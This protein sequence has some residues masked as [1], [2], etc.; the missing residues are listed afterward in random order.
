ML[1]QIFLSCVHL[2]TQRLKAAAFINNV[3][4]S[5]DGQ[6]WSSPYEFNTNGLWRV[7]SEGG[8]YFPDG[9]NNHIPVP[10]KQSV[11]QGAELGTVSGPIRHYSVRY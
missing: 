9:I 6:H 8:S 2:K 4:T 7:P 10:P 5:Q 11:F 3:G 1:N